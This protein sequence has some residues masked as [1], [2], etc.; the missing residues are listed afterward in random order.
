L[1]CRCALTKRGR[2]TAMVVVIQTL[3]DLAAAAAFGTAAWQVFGGWYRFRAGRTQRSVKQGPF[4]AVA[5]VTD[6]DGS[7]EL[8]LL[9][10]SRKGVGEG[11]AS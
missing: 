10:E 5:K 11:G 2:D 1:P 6:A 7:K 8:S 9:E 3:A 4:D